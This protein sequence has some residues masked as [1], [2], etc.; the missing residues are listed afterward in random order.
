MGVTDGRYV[1]RGGDGGCGQRR[2]QCFP[3]LCRRT[4]HVVQVQRV[5]R[6]FQALDDHCPAGASLREVT[7]QVPGDVEVVKQAPQLFV[8]DLQL[9]RTQLVERILRG[10]Q[11][12]AE[13]GWCAAVREQVGVG[14]GLHQELQRRSGL[15]PF[16]DH[17]RTV[18]RVDGFQHPQSGVEQ[19]PLAL[20]AWPG[21]SEP[22][23][24]R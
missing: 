12:I 8:T 5:E 23:I 21:I 9:S 22:E 3:C 2:G 6:T 24:H 10:G 17:R 4:G 7:R 14:G 1:Q 20:V 16:S 19:Q 11:A 15:C 13:L 18:P